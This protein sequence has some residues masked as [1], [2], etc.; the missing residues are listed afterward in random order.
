MIFAAGFLLLDAV[1]LVLA[2]VWMARVALIVWGG[3]F[4]IGAAW[5]VVLWRRYLVRLSEL[6]DARAALRREIHRISRTI[7]EGS[8]G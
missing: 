5:V 1:L 7:E 8:R 2:G 4:A 6:D 3:V